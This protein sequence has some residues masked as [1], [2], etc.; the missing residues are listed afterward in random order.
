MASVD[1]IEGVVY[2]DQP[3]GTEALIA[4]LDQMMTRPGQ[5]RLEHPVIHALER[6]EL[7]KNQI[8]GWI[9]QITCWANPTNILLGSLYAR[10]QDE[11]LRKMVLDNLSEEE[12]GTESGTAGHIE[13]FE[14]TFTELGWDEQRRRQEPVL[15]DTWALAHWFEVVL[16]QRPIAEGIA[17]ASFSAERINPLCFGRIEK[18]MRKHYAISDYGLQSIAVHASHVEV[19]HGSLGPA[20]FA[21]YCT[22]ADAQNRLR[23]TVAHTNELYYRQWMSFKHYA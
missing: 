22:T 17:A 19:E 7:S 6:G 3:I 23:F 10:C 1:A 16:T 15:M 13:L 9:Y 8:A 4:E 20:A 18:A 12:Y 11:D 21:R 2:R 5:N 14:R